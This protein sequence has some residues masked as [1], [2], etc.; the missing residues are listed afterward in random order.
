MNE[1]WINENNKRNE[2][3]IKNNI[4][5]FDKSQR[6]DNISK[7]TDGKHKQTHEVFIDIIYNI[8]NKYEND[9]I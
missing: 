2:L 3:Y 7:N 1:I 9:K 5:K 4:P 6:I 8:I